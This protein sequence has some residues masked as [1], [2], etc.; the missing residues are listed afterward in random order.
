MFCQSRS[1]ESKRCGLNTQAVK[2][3]EK[4]AVHLCRICRDSGKSNAES[5]RSPHCPVSVTI[6]PPFESVSE[7]RNVL[8]SLVTLRASFY[9]Q[10]DCG[11]LKGMKR[12]DGSSHFPPRQFPSHTVVSSFVVK[13]DIATTCTGELPFS[14]HKPASHRHRQPP[15]RANIRRLG[16]SHHKAAITGRGSGRERQW[17]R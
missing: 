5:P 15:Q 7:R 10:D 11:V 3:K 1:R 8:P 2:G 14:M 9:I 12:S 17:K 16:H 6:A 13:W 4:Q